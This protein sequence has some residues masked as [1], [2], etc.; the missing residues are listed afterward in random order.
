MDSAH[1]KQ[2]HQQAYNWPLFAQFLGLFTLLATAFHASLGPLFARWV[3]WDEDLSHGIPTLIAFLFLLLR[4][5]TLPYRQDARWL[6]LCLIAGV[7]LLSLCWLLFVIANITILANIALLMCLLVLVAASYSLTSAR[8]LLPLLGILVFTIPLFG[9]INN[10]LVTMSAHAVSVLV[11]WVG[12]TALIDGQS[13]FIPSGHIYIA[14]GCSGLRYFTI[15]IFLGYTLAILNHYRLKAALITLAIALALGLITNWLRI[16]LL[17]V[18]GDLTEMQSSLMHDHELFGWVLFACVMFPAIYF[19][20]IKPAKLVAA[21]IAPRIKPILPLAA[22]LTGPLLLALIPNT[23]HHHAQLSLQLLA[24]VMP[25]TTGDSAFPLRTPAGHAEEF[26]QKT[27]NDI[28]FQ[29]QLTQYQPNTLKEKIVPYFDSLYSSDEWRS[30]PVANPLNAQG[31]RVLRLAKMR[32]AES[33]VLIYRLEI[34]KFNTGSYQTAKLL[35]I[36]ATLLGNRYANVFSLQARC[37]DAE[38]SAELTEATALALE[39]DRVTQPLR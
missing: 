20:P 10:L 33:R 16:F 30:E 11:Q 18:I 26:A 14:D 17:V 8:Y 27:R 31:F 25:H 21:P 2:P 13:I 12:M 36:P 23:A 39:W 7:L 37:K 24:P 32:G 19:A 9:D 28:R 38:C 22:L 35:Q 34:G 6:R 3:K 1:A 29:L 5:Q 15:A 4:S